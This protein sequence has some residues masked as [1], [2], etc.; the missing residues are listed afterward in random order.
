MPRFSRECQGT[1]LTF[2]PLDRPFS[3]FDFIERT[4]PEVIPLRRTFSQVRCHNA[5]TLVLE[6]LDWTTADDLRTENEDIGKR[7]DGDVRS[8]VIRL[9]F[10]T[11]PIG[12]RRSLA[13]VASSQFIGYATVKQDA[14]SGGHRDRIFESVI[15]PS[16]HENNFIRGAGEWTCRVGGENFSLKGYLYAQQNNMTNVCAHV[17][18]RTVAARFHADGDMSY[19]E[20]NDLPGVGIDHVSKRVGNG[21]GLTSREMMEI[22]ETAGARCVVGDFTS[23]A[24]GTTAPPFQKF[25][26]GSIESGYPAIVCFAAGNGQYH[27]I[28]VFG[29]TFNEDTWVPNAEF[30]YFR[31]GHGTAYIP[32]ES[33]VSSYVAHDDNW[34]SNYC[35]PRHFLYTKQNCDRLAGGTRPCVMESECVAYII[36]TLPKAAMVSPISAEVIGADFLFSMLPQLTAMNELWGQRLQFYARRHLLVLR[37]ILIDEGR[38]LRHLAAIDDWDGNRIRP[39]LLTALRPLAKG[40]IWMVELSVPELFSANRRKLGEVLVAADSRPNTARDFKNYLLT[41]VPGYF[42]LHQGGA[43]SSPS[44][45]FINAGLQGHVPLYGCESYGL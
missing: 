10:F 15:L 21:V 23:I 30:S 14:W 28:P 34:G 4:F 45:A 42:V 17:A 27:A 19:R 36:A 18:C 9:S 16:R 43:A 31:V 20:M 41:R 12:D 1:E 8:R 25:L 2:V 35:V 37:P 33:W 13:A 24:P 5:R 44:Y 38:Y 39:E 26:Y 22:L 29:H 11:E 7:I 3:N 6:K 32:S 40:P